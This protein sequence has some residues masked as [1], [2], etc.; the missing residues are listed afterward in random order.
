MWIWAHIASTL[1]LSVIFMCTE[2]THTNT[3]WMNF[4][5]F[6]QQQNETKKQNTIYYVDEMRDH[7]ID[8]AWIHEFE[9]IYI[10][11][12]RESMCL[13]C[14]NG[15]EYSELVYYVCNVYTSL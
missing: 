1:P 10:Y 6:S 12:E 13:Q 11:I 15:S 4:T 3:Q 5:L 9:R 14:V 7:D 2:H 8:T